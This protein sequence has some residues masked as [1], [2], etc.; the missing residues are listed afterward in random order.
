MTLLIASLISSISFNPISS[1]VCSYKAFSTANLM[2]NLMSSDI[3]PYIL[4]EL[5]VVIDQTVA[6]IGL[7][8]K[9]PSDF[10]RNVTVLG[11]QNLERLLS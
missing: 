11:C 2:S 4:K 9:N 1:V 5:D 10:T 7:Y 6:N 8:T 3:Q